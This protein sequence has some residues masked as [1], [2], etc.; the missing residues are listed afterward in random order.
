MSADAK[1]S[2]SS[3]GGGGGGSAKKRLMS[4]LMEMQN[5]PPEGC[6]AAPANESN[7]FVWNASIIGPDESPWE[8]GIYGLRMMFPE[9]YPSKPPKVSCLFVCSFCLVFE[10]RLFFFFRTYS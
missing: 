9:T 6:S 4:D 8:G 1:S 3:S 7:L 10:N 5:E 2:S